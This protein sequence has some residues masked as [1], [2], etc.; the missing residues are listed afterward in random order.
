MKRY[1]TFVLFAVSLNAQYTAT[2]SHFMALPLDGDRPWRLS[3]LGNF[4]GRPALEA[5][6]NLV[7]ALGAGFDL[8][9]GLHGGSLAEK[10]PGNGAGIVGLDLMIRY[11]RPVSSSL[12]LGAQLQGG[13]TY[14]GIGQMGYPPNYA[15]AIPISFGIAFG[16][17][18]REAAALYI[19]PVAEFGQT[20]HNGDPVWKSGI[21]LRFTLGS[22]MEISER[23]RLAIE[24]RPAL[25]DFTADSV[26]SSLGIDAG[27]GVLFDF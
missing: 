6:L 15:S 3:I 22:V 20:M 7:R 23:V 14:T 2:T 24:V 25:H 16:G 21:G 27:L 4:T 10:S 5:D 11:L 8:G 1:I 12:F 17:Y 26:W 13:Y 18:L 9:F 19:F